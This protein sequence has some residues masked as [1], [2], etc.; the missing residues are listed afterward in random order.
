MNK[1]Y[2]LLFFSFVFNNSLISQNLIKGFSISGSGD[3]FVIKTTIEQNDNYLVGGIFKNTLQIAS[4]VL[5]SYGN[6]YDIFIC[7]FSKDDSLLWVKQIGSS[8]YD[9]LLE[10]ISVDKISN[11]II[12][13]GSFKGSSCDFGGELALTNSLVNTFDAFIC[14]INSINGSFISATKLAYGLNNERN[15]AVE[16]DKNGDIIVV[17]F[18]QGS[19]YSYFTT[20]DSSLCSGPRNYYIYKLNSAFQKVWLKIYRGSNLQN[21][22]FSV[23]SDN[24]S[25]Y[26]AG[27]YRDS[28]YLDIKTLINNNASIDIF[29]YKTDFQGN[30]QWIRTIKGSADDI[31][32]G[33]N[34][35]NLGNVYL[36]GYFS[37]N[38]LMVDSLENVTSQRIASTNG[39]NDLFF[40]K[41]TTDGQLLWFDTEGS[42]GDDRLTRLYTNGHYIVI[43][44]QFAGS[45]T[46]R[47]EV[48][49]PRGGTDGLSI[50]Y[51]AN[52]N[53]LYAIPIGGTG[54][55]VTQT[56]LIDSKGNYIFLGNFYSPTLYLT[57]T[58]T[59]T[60]PTPSTRDVFIA[61]YDKASIEIAVTPIS[62]SNADDGIAVANPQGA[63]YGDVTVTWTKKDNPS[64]NKSGFT[65]NNLSPGT[66]YCHVTDELGYAK[67]DSFTLTNPEAMAVSVV[68]TTPVSCYG[69]SN[70]AIDITPSGGTAPYTYL[71]YT[72]NGS[73]LQPAAQ[74]QFTLTAGTYSVTITD[75]KG[76]SKLSPDINITQPAPLMINVDSVHNVT[77][78]GAYDGAVFT[79]ASGGTSPYTYL[80][81]PGNYTTGD[82]INVSGNNY[83][84]TVID[85]KGCTD[86]T[87]A[88]VYEPGVLNVSYIK[89]DVSCYGQANGAIDLTLTGDYPPFSF[90]WTKDGIPYGGNQEDLTGLAAGTYEVT[91]QDNDSPPSVRVITIVISQPAQLTASTLHTD[92]TCSGICNGII[93]LTISGGT[94]PYIFA[95][96]Q[97]G[98]PGF[99]RTTEDISALCQGVYRVTVTDSKGCSVQAFDSISQPAPL[100]IYDMVTNVSCR[101]GRYDGIIDLTVTGGNPPYTFQWSNGMTTEDLADLRPGTYCVTV[102][103]ANNCQF[104][105]C[106]TVN[107][108]LPFDFSMKTFVH[109]S[110]YGYSDGSIVQAVT[111]GN[112]PYN[113]Q[114]NTG[115][116]TVS[117][118]GKPAGTYWVDITDSKGCTAADTTVL[119]EPSEVVIQVSDLGHVTCFGANDGHAGVSVTGGTPPYSY[120]WTPGNQITASVTALAAGSYTVRVR[121]NNLCQKNMDISI[122]QPAALALSE[123]PGFHTDN[124]C[125]QN[126]EGKL[127]VHPS[128][129][130]GTYEFSI[131]GFVWQDDSA[132]VGLLGGTYQVLVRDKLYPSCVISSPLPVIITRPPMLVFNIPQDT[133]QSSSLDATVYASGGVPPYTFNITPAAD[134]DPEGWFTH[135]AEGVSYIITLNDANNCGPVNDTVIYYLTGLKDLITGGMVTVY[136]NPFYDNLTVSLLNAVSGRW[137][138]QLVNSLGQTVV[139]KQVDAKKDSYSKVALPVQNLPAGIYF[140]KVRQGNVSEVLKVVKR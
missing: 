64:F 82:I 135:L 96:T 85:S 136:P 112:P 130:Y 66:Y 47:N 90:S 127:M 15:Q 78:K 12:V 37:S 140:L 11:N 122:N 134:E 46:F 92:I 34:A 50:V 71:W 28:F 19:N 3:N 44:G 4:I 24:S 65:V 43:A 40:A 93:D 7:K 52:D 16:I 113:Y 118:S 14:K 20:T 67:T 8:G 9:D 32:I 23:T 72:P 97:D 98:D 120:L 107:E 84:V 77:A 139:E 137:N 39:N 79:T 83:S 89:N 119:L 27:T 91:V 95:W 25:Y 18:F 59:L 5:N 60:N 117:V 62:C 49:I 48:L 108:P 54:N 114:W 104:F 30:G 132:F 111:G 88:F 128:G 99:S 131:D 124:I 63:W 76:C 100:I 133:I 17:G 53:L 105:N 80:W 75:S 55:D 81:T 1:I 45:M 115:E 26:F 110:C 103:D 57:D 73:G 121:D 33:A 21:G 70:G 10:G 51:D 125:Y 61:K 35:D 13:T 36:S 109:P 126:N 87:A 29:I 6:A 116:T 58:Y 42:T 86:D 138:L 101:G 31:S 74:D 56:C 68:S 106:Y 69:G 41:Y 2:I 94:G 102:K 22:L 123:D 129:G 38:D